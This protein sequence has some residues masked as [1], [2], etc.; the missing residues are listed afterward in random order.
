MARLKLAYIF[1]SMYNFTF[2]F[3]KTHVC[4]QVFAETRGVQYLDFDD[5]DQLSVNYRDID[6]MN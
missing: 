1:C 6:L 3:L 4:V 5:I 2:V